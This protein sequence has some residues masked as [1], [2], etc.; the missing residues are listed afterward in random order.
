M[1]NG[2][3]AWPRIRTRIQSTGSGNP[4]QMGHVPY[5]QRSRPS[6]GGQAGSEYRDVAVVEYRFM[7]VR[8]NMQRTSCPQMPQAGRCRGTAAGLVAHH[9]SKQPSIFK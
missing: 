7:A 4:Q 6:A 2:L 5:R 9:R 1:P 8:A 3:G